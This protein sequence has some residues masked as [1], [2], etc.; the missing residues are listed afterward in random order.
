VSEEKTVVLIGGL[1]LV[2]VIFFAFMRQQQAN[3]L[4]ALNQPGLLTQ[5]SLPAPTGTLGQILSGLNFAGPG[6][7]SLGAGLSSFASAVGSG[8]SPQSSGSNDPTLEGSDATDFPGMD[9]SYANSNSYVTPFDTSDTS[10]ELG[11]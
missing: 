2:A 4:A 8:F 10:A 3:Q 1:A 11:Y 5:P 7:A 6:L 9:Y